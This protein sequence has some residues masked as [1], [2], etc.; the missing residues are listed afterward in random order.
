[1]QRK[2]IEDKDLESYQMTDDL[3]GIKDKIIEAVLPEI[4]FDGWTWRCVQAAAVKAGYDKDMADAVF[5]SGLCDVLAHFSDWIDRQ[6]MG[7]LEDIDP[8]SLR[9]RDRIHEAVMTRIEV[10]EPY[11]DALQQAMAY[12]SLPHRVPRA[13]KVMWRTADRIWNWAGDTATDYNHYTKRGLLCGVMSSTILA[14][15][16]DSSN[17]MEAVEAF[18]DRRINNVLTI[19]KTIGRFKGR[20]AA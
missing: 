6:M 3:T 19:G 18:L 12:W 8:D 9:I 4:A 16:N 17:D 11:K 7:Q 15:V 20:S 10:L 14:W 13:G 1:M 2:D 5:P